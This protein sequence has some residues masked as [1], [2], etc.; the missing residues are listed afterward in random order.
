MSTY[1]HERSALLLVIHPR[2]SARPLLWWESVYGLETNKK[3]SASAYHEYL[4]TR[5]VS[6]CLRR[7]AVDSEELVEVD[8]N[9]S[10]KM[11]TAECFVYC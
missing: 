8:Q 5:D 4:V 3:P 10:W 7:S 1:L 11:T 9:P 6:G 2:S